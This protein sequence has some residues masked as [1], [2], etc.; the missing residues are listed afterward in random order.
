MA[1]CGRRRCL[2]RTVAGARHRGRVV[3]LRARF[4]QKVP[5]GQ[6]QTVREGAGRIPGRSDESPCRPPALAA[7]LAHVLSRE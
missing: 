3:G 7:F 4:C 2:G 6:P 1:I 5:R